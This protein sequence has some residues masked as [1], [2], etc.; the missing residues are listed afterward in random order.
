MQ[1]TVSASL[2]LASKSPA[3]KEIL[4]RAG[5]AF[6]VD[7]AGI[8]ER[9]IA[10]DQ[11][12]P[13]EQAASLAIAKARAVAAS[14]PDAVVIGADQ[15]LG[16]EGRV[17]HTPPDLTAARERLRTLS[18]R[19]HHLHT[20]VSLVRNGEPVWQH[21]ETASLTMRPLTGDEIDVVLAQEGD[22]ALHSVGAYRLEG[23]GVRLFETIEG[24]YF[25]ILGL[26]LLPLL[27]A[28]RQHAPQLLDF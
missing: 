10:N 25:S 24:D 15:I 6:A 16:F 26:P 11:Q 4:T 1:N 17:L 5:L 9:A 18:G 22:R 19:T 28:L 23:P 2:V 27:S 7:A 21:L 8:N 13:Q 12:L 20:A 14:H 3:R